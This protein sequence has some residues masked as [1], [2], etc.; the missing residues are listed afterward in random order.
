ML[1]LRHLALS[2]STAM[3]LLG[4]LSTTTVGAAAPANVPPSPPVQAS[5][6]TP[7]P[8]ASIA[9]TDRA[10]VL[11]AAWSSSP[12]LSW[13][14]TPSADGLVVY[15]ARPSEGMSWQPRTEL[16][17]SGIASRQWIGQGCVLRGTHT[18]AV[19]FGPVEY[20]STSALFE[21]GAFVSLVDLDTGI[22]IPTAAR[23]TFSY[24]SPTCGADGDADLTTFG[25]SEQTTTVER[26]DPRGHLRTVVSAAAG[27]YIGA[28][29][30]ASGQLIATHGSDLVALGPLGASTL[31]HGSDPL[32]Q[33]HL[34]PS[35]TPVFTSTHGNTATVQALTGTT[36]TALATGQ[37]GDLGI[38]GDGQGHVLIHASAKAQAIGKISD[39]RVAQVPANAQPS[40][41]GTL[42][43]NSAAIDAAHGGSITVT[44]G[45]GHPSA[46]LALPTNAGV[47]VAGS[48]TAANTSPGYPSSMSR[49]SKTTT[50][51]SAA[52]TTT[53]QTTDSNLPCAVQRNDVRTQAFQPSVD[54][55]EYAVDLAVQGRLTPSRPAGYR[56]F[57]LP[58]YSPQKLEPI[59][60]LSGG[61]S[62]P[63]QIMLGIL[64][65]ESNL[66][67]ASSH[68]SSGGYGNP[69]TG[70]IYGRDGQTLTINFSKADCG[71][72]V[73]QVTD[74]MRTGQQN[75]TTQ[76]AIALDYQVNIAA[77]LDILISKWNQ[78]RS[79][80]QPITMNN[81][82]PQWLE[83]WYAA[84]WAYN[85]GIQP[86]ANNG[87]LTG[88]APGPKC[89]DA[90]G[91]WGLGWANNPA[92]P[93]YPASRHLFNSSVYD[94]TTPAQWPYQE[95]VLGWAAYP[96]Y[97]SD[98]ES[99][100]QAW[101]T[102]DANRATA[103]PSPALFCT[104]ANG[105]SGASTTSQ[106]TCSPVRNYHC[107]TTFS[108]TWKNCT[109]GSCGH[110]S[111]YYSSSDPEPADMITAD[112][113][114]CSTQG[115]PAGAVVVD[116][117]PSSTPVAGTPCTAAPTVGSF[118]FTFTSDQNGQYPAHIDLHQVNGGF[119]GHY[120][121]THTLQD[122]SGSLPSFGTWTFPSTLTGWGSVYVH[123][124][125]L[126]A[127]TTQAHYQVVDGKSG[128]S[129]DR[130]IS[131]Y[132]G[133]NHWFRLGAYN[134]TAGE[135][136][137]GYSLS[138][139]DSGSADFAWDSVA[140]VPTTAP[141]SSVA[142]IGDSYSAGEG[143]EPYF[144]D[145][146]NQADGTPD[147]C[148]R[149]SK[150][151]AYLFRLPDSSVPVGQRTDIDL[152]FDACSGAHTSSITSAATGGE[153]PPDSGW[154]AQRYEHG[155]SMQVDDANSNPA[156][157]GVLDSNTSIVALTVGGNDARFADI[158]QYCTTNI[159]KD[160]NAPG[161]VMPG[162]PS[163]L[164]QYEPHVI[165]DLLPAHLTAAYNA[166]HNAAPNAAIY[167]LGY[168]H[169]F[170]PAMACNAISIGEGAW[171][172]SM[173]DQLDTT[174]NTV[175][176]KLS[177]QGVRVHYVSTTPR[178]VNHAVC[179]Y[180]E[181]IND[182]IIRSVSGSGSSVPGTGSFHPNLAGQQAF[183]DALSQ[184]IASS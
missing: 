121:F 22:V 57:G 15:T 9:P 3:M 54:Q 59:T 152:R 151:Y 111:A 109:G 83:N 161:Q 87:N 11:G 117:V 144:N 145:A 173:A 92:N 10:A 27:E 45:A 29:A 114:T 148:H 160:C 102:S 76:R 129:R 155:E 166:I 24:F 115:L 39:V 1:S 101:W 89:T 55:I 21:Q 178:F 118:A 116:D 40:V 146:D 63:P 46:Q 96:I 32:S 154:N 66:W 62:V 38:D 30:Q 164:A 13:S 162:D 119:N 112:P 170:D 25:P 44:Q 74:G 133:S 2:V 81:G 7:V 14:L 18:L 168:P 98:Q 90:N 131:Q 35:G 108:V 68:V 41:D 88:C 33:L 73:A 71:Y 136:L 167:V 79:L 37:A 126:G 159:A 132:W 51:S 141:K 172:N 104:A 47:T 34:T 91:Y 19:A 143:L 65:N 106:G 4:G 49:S 43:A 181:W 165:N 169:L 150:A 175:V 174:I 134:F 137:R 138:A 85:T 28:V 97:K 20:I 77:G 67:Q 36:V 179:D 52:A 70:N 180:D 184:A 42:W 142:V 128:I 147:A 84:V 157:S 17:V 8:N 86:D 80:S 16:N 64:A 26:L 75:A 95:R 140:F 50:A 103:V 120:W 69:L 61:G 113:A 5:A 130:W 105:C 56:Q 60:A 123:V 99:Y 177:S 158:V 156:V 93:M 48:S 12:D 182:I 53:S 110:S 58:A 139:H 72:G 183:A 163:P 82:D 23:A 135:K 122:T 94:A 153:I 149:S 78:L 127:Q 31:H 176:T 125:A 6:A 107:W 100:S 171:L 124:P